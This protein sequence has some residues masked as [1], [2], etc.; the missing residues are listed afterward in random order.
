MRDLFPRSIRFKL[1]FLGRTPNEESAPRFVVAKHVAE[2][3]IGVLLILIGQPPALA[4]FQTL[5]ASPH[6]TTKGS[7]RQDA[8]NLPPL[9]PVERELKGGE[10]HSYQVALEAGQF[11]YAQVEQQGID[12]AIDVFDPG[13]QKIAD[14]DSPND[15]WGAEPILLVAGSSGNYRV[16]IRSPNKTALNGS[17]R[18]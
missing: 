16:D 4:S 12:L 3:L 7:L 13:G 5:I 6:A 8:G 2:I 15:N 10:T 9:S 11:L 18:D 17:L 14:A 1:S